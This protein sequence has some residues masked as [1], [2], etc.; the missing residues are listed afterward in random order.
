MSGLPTS[1]TEGRPEPRTQPH[2]LDAGSPTPRGDVSQCRTT[3]CRLAAWAVLLVAV[4]L[5]VR[6]SVAHG[7]PAAS[8]LV[9]SDEAR[10]FLVLQYRS[11]S[12]EFM[13]CLIGEARGGTV[14]VDR[15]APADVEPSHSTATHV[16]PKQSCERAGWS[17]TVGMIHS[18]P[19]GE[20]CWYYF[21]GTQVLSSD[22]QAFLHQP[23]PVDAIMCGDR[24][25]WISRDQ[26]ERQLTPLG[27]ANGL[28]PPPESD[29]VKGA[30]HDRSSDEHPARYRGSRA[31]SAAARGTRIS[32]ALALRGRGRRYLLARTR[33]GRIRAVARRGDRR[34]RVARPRPWL[35]NEFPVAQGSTARC[36]RARRI[37]ARRRAGS[38]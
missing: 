20:H 2:C 12:T 23:Y 3:K 35:S 34:A 10:R 1:W 7:G 17:G 16:V 26:V 36:G 22:G 37:K 29:D 15:I 33:P 14:R 27:G 8:T 25:V 19:G 38:G 5:L 18:H 24:V 30:S 28:R 6:M 11:F 9:L 32:L 4:G 13:G 21:P 31:A